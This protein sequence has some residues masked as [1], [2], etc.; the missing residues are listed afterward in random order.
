MNTKNMIFF[1]LALGLFAGALYAIG[2]S[3]NVDYVE[4]GRFEEGAI[5]SQEI[6]GGNVTTLNIEANQSTT[7]WAGFKGNLTG[8]LILSENDETDAFYIWDWTQAADSVVCASEEDNYDWSAPVAITA[9][10]L[11]TALESVDSSY[12]YGIDKVTE[13]F[14]D[15]C[16]SMTIAGRD[17]TNTAA[18]DTTNPTAETCVINNGASDLAFCT[19]TLANGAFGL[20]VPATSAVTYYFYVELV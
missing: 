15:D 7:K 9:N 17:H 1:V 13:T 8:S 20:L 4:S 14:D 19:L 3:T 2:N 16:A 6:D 11:E 18:A 5:G 12:S 10:N